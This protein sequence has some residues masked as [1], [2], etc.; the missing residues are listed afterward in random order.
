V[1]RATAR[2]GESAAVGYPPQ[3]RG[4]GVGGGAPAMAAR[5]GVFRP[6]CFLGPRWGWGE[7]VRPGP[8]P[9]G[10]GVSLLGGISGDPK[11][12]VKKSPAF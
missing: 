9:Q 10:S 12:G 5:A 4:A 8:I 6:G 3:D 11:M 7:G 1:G 2:V